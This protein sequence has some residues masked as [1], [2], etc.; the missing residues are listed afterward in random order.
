MSA[1]PPGPSTTQP[2]LRLLVCSN[3]LKDVRAALDDPAF[4]G[5]ELHTFPACTGR[6]LRADARVEEAAHESHTIVLGGSCGPG[7]TAGVGQAS[8][9]LV[10]YHD[11]QALE[12]YVRDGAY[13]LT[14]GWLVG[15]RGRMK[16]WGLDQATARELFAE[17]CQRLLLLDTGT[18]GP[19]AERL[20]ELSEYLDVPAEVLD[21]GVGHL[22]LYLSRLV[23]E[24]RLSIAEEARAAADRSKA[25]HAAAVEL[26]SSLAELQDEAEVIAGMEA[27]FASLFAAGHLDYQ[28]LDP[29]E[30]QAHAGG[31]P[32]A[33]LESGTGFRLR[34][35]HGEITLG[36]VELDQFT[37]PQHRQ[38]Y[39]DLALQIGAVAGLAIA[40][41]RRFEALRRAE[42]ETRRTAAELA[43]SN[44]E[45]EQYAAVSSHDLQEPL[46]KI[47]A[48]GDRLSTRN[49]EQLDA[50][51]QDYLR[52]MLNSATRMRTL[53][54]DLLAYSR[55][56]GASVRC[57]PVD[58]DALLAEV[59][60][61]LQ[62]RLAKT[63]GLLEVGPLPTLEADAT[64][65][66]Q[67]FQNLIG[68]ALKFVRP[69]VP[70]RV[71]VHALEA[72]DA[73]L[74]R[75]VIQDNGIGIAAEHLDR[76]FR[77]FRRL[78][79]RSDYE[80]T[81][82]GLAICRRVVERHHGTLQVSSVLGEGS[83]FTLT[84]PL[85]APEDRD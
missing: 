21:V 19:V 34:I 55:A 8:H 76:I 79:P 69:G 49:T 30:S 14:T 72:C 42:A 37:F 25:D 59:V 57:G 45:L 60:E 16:A 23:L 43:R 63:G 26:I 39:L 28:P 71:Q 10:W 32:W 13:V 31:P 9:C 35:E 22:R 81:G 80:G 1:P 2:A 65:M 73:G 52:R 64:G 83:T 58:L 53:I 4:S 29:E 11:Q 46:R 54:D 62:G 38:A 5:V 70:P 82:I 40:N 68:N 77:V 20:R 24:R 44:E 75:I 41:A 51:G 6:V 56:Q 78:H 84:L 61:D 3:H 48:F 36:V 18:D 15:W 7:N 66:R 74:S 33:W 85:R 50:R 47:L 17:T 67:I 27:L 12:R